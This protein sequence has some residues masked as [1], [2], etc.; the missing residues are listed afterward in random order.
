MPVSA[1]DGT[2]VSVG[3]RPEHVVVRES[4]A[5]PVRGVVELVERLGAET[6]AHVSIVSERQ[7]FTVVARVPE[8]KSP[9]E[10]EAVALGAKISRLSLF[11]AE[12][13]RVQAA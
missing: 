6:L 1:P 8:G 9:T 3:V 11:D 4:T 7:M 5:T 13:R 10:G 2:Q 12:G